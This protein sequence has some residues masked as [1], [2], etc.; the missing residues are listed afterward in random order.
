MTG[1]ILTR[2]DLWASCKDLMHVRRMSNGWAT[3]PSYTDTSQGSPARSLSVIGSVS[4]TQQKQT[5]TGD[6]A[7][8]AAR[9]GNSV[10]GIASVTWR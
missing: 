9:D 8:S 4:D 5:E 7:G 6:L 1:E 10:D 3:A 2:A